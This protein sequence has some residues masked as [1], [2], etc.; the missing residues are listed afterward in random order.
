VRYVVGVDGGGTRTRAVIVDDRGV[1]RGRVEGPGAVATLKWPQDAAG[2]VTDVVRSAAD[3][4]GLELP[5]EV[6]WA[7]LAGAGADA[8]RRAVRDSLA[9]AG[10]AA[11]VR[12]G[13]DAE[14]A[15]HGAFGDGP[16]I[17][18]IAGTGSIAWGRGRDGR[19]ARVGGWGQRLG[20]EG[21]GYAIG[22][23]ALRG[24]LRAFDGRD[25]PT[26][27]TDAVLELCDVGDPPGL[28]TWIESA[29][30]AEVAA[31]VP[32]VAA[33]AAQRDP[34]APAILDRAAAELEEHVAALLRATGPW[35][36]PAPLVVWGGLL[37]GGGP[38]RAAT[39][40][41]L[42]RYPVSLLD[43]EPDPPAGAA[44]LALVE[45]AGAD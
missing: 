42:D 38:L 23:D 3:R 35:D 29:P 6:L 4:A 25:A 43:I 15:F 14:A 12:V 1:E 31:L 5:V 26:Q 16:G 11:R 20:D 33:A 13:T 19:L 22:L 10:L 41:A 24:V 18:L 17:L 36:G 21:S 7:G 44:G 8:A 39:L 9:K 2:A 28:V 30:K 34:A 45:L 37:A 32:V 27:M 40:R